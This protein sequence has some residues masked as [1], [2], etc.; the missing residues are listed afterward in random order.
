MKSLNPALKPFWKTK[1]DIKILKGGRSSSKTWDCCGF[2][3]FLSSTYSMKICCVRQ[4]QNRIADSV[5]T[6][7]VIQINRF[8]L[9]SE[10][11]VQKNKIIHL[12]TGSEFVFYGIQRNINEIKGLEG[13]DILY[14]EEAQDLSKA[15]WEIIS[16]TIRK[17][18][19]EIWMLYNPHLVSDF[20]EMEFKHDPDN[21]VIVRHINY[22]ENPFLSNTMK[23]KI[24][25]HKDADYE[26]YEHI[27]LGQ[28]KM[29]DDSV[30]IKRSWINAAIDA[31]KK[32]ELDDA[33][34]G[35]TIG[36]FDVADS[37]NDLCSYVFRVGIVAFACEHWKGKE[38]ELL[39]SATRVYNKA[40]LLDADVNYDSIGVGAG[41]GPKFDELNTQRRES[42]IDGNI[43][44]NKFVAGAKVVNPDSYYIDAEKEKV[45]NKDYFANLKA[46]AWWL[47]ADRFRNT[48]NA[49]INGEQFDIDKMI[50]ID[51][52]IENLENLITELSTPRRHF[53]N[54][55]RVKVESKE[56]LAKRDV[57]SPNDADAFIMAYAPVQQGFVPFAF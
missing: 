1:A 11:D 21:G 9:E 22:D 52:D 56:D 19:A 31:H 10:F 15:Q 4:F 6:N 47:V 27:Y 42:G 33:K 24:Q 44:Y 39:K 7:L 57:A 3:I 28:A 32:L 50:A 49:V 26:D 29:D 25:R 54:A 45:T 23:R 34:H 8:G 43:G 36:G 30:V 16:P 20:V 18:N 13:I 55:G 37:G 17:E 51:G 48:Y 46:Q 14:I 5:Y 53:D 12:E 38:D 35:A 41:V 2:L 40:V